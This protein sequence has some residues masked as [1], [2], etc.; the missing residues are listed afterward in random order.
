MSPKISKKLLILIIL[1]PTIASAGIITFFIVINLQNESLESKIQ[2]WM[3]N[4]QIPSLGACIV[5]NDSVTWAQGFG[6]QPDLNT[7]YMIGSITK[8]FTATA[9]L[10]LYEN[11]S[12]DLND[13]I[14]D[15]LPFNVRHPDYPGWDVTIEMV[16]TH[17][18]GL[19]GNLFWSLEY[20]LDNKTITWIN[21]NLE[22]DIIIWEDR[23][24]LEQF[25]N[26]SLN[27]IG[28][29]YNDHNWQSRPG[30]TF[31]YSNA[32]YQLLGYLVE[33][34]TNQSIMDYVQENIFDPL[35]MNRSSYY[36]EDFL[37]SNAIPY[38]W[39]N[40]LIE[41]P[42]YNINVTGAG[43]I[44]STIPDM[45]KYLTMFMNNGKCK[46]IQILK[47]ESIGLMHS[48]HEPL[49][50]TSTE[51]FDIEGYG[52][53]WFLYGGGYKGH[54]GATPGFSSNMFFKNSSGHT[55]G[56]FVTFNRGSALLLDESLLNIYIPEI[57]K[58][59]LEE[60]ELLFQQAL[61]S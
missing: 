21:E 8:S 24:T 27:P 45:A 31:L 5:I 54:G 52:Y 49:T 35:N 37:S 32:G 59:L 58:I 17:T 60:S 26:E 18:A 61:S 28:E 2:S 57:N 39:N 56:V 11:G 15:Y 20:Y 42:L 50:G 23:P 9:I 6:D 36:Y 46:G 51:G 16:L 33:E 40:S 19:P 53:G 30:S 48:N 25:L 14:D 34:I 1:V 44:R 13:N 7:V 12:L 47:P 38:E 41:L 43:A 22:W 10:Q 3:T 29:Y 55:V 4:A